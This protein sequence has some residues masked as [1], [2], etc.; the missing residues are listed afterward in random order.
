MENWQSLAVIVVLN[1]AGYGLGYIAVLQWG[2]G[3]KGPSKFSRWNKRGA[4]AGLLVSALLLITFPIWFLL[5]FSYHALGGF[6]FSAAREAANAIYLERSGERY[7]G[8]HY[9]WATDFR[10]RIYPHLENDGDVSHLGH[11]TLFKRWMNWCQKHDDV[12]EEQVHVV[13]DSEF[14][15]M[16]AG[17]W[18]EFK[19][20]V[21]KKEAKEG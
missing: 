16:L 9:R 19:Q 20:W 11:E 15:E 8:Q 14:E 2:F 5:W 7:M 12:P 17:E 13:T 4:D 21:L 10:D 18:R 3:R 6:G 1:L